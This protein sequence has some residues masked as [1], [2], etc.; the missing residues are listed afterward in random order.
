MDHA[1]VAS[2]KAMAMP[3]S[4]RASWVRGASS[5]LY[6]KLEYNMQIAQGGIAFQQST[7]LGSIFAIEATA[8]AGAYTCRS[9]KPR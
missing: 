6:K 2:K 1:A 4:R 8:Q 9:S 5:R 3:T 7:M